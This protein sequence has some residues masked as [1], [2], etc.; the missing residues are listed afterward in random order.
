MK[1]V[2][3]IIQ[4]I[5]SFL[6]IALIFLQATGENETRSNLLALA[7][8]KRGWDKILF[9]FTILIFVLFLISCVFQALAN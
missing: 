9:N 6:L 3:E 8:E 4:I 1:P 5:L 7:S 2:L